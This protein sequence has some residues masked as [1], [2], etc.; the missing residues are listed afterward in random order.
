MKVKI[1]F[2]LGFLV[3]SSCANL[4][5]IEHEKLYIVERESESLAVVSRESTK[6]ISQLG[7]MNHATMKF[8]KGY[9]YILAR[10]GFIS[11]IDVNKDELVKKVKIGKSGIGLTFSED[12][13]VIVNYDPNSVVIL[14]LDL[15]V[16]KTIETPSRNVGVKFWNNLLVFSLMDS[17][18]IWV[19]D[20]NQDYKIVKKFNDVGLLPFDALVKD[21]IYIVGFFN[22]NSIGVLDLS[23]LA[24]QKLAL[25]GKDSSATYKVPHFGYWGI[26][27]DV[28]LVPL[29]S[30]TSL[31]AFDL[32]TLAPIKEIPLIGKPVF[33]S[34]SPDKKKVVVSYSGDKENYISIVDTNSM[35]KIQ[36]VK[37]GERVMHLRYSQD[38]LRLYVTS[39]FD[40]KLKIFN[41]DDW[42]LVKEEKISAPSGIFIKE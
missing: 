29:V 3:L 20:K 12:D 7:N 17:N 13:V 24:Y 4:K 16:K 14:D 9:G 23:K 18:Q 10:D 8:H 15:N 36:D 26:V 6:K 35:Q 40:N 30:G 38:G 5:R 19:L 41:T 21:N 28:A 31:L 37:A 42:K 22:E 2:L 25:A 33:A 27:N 34:V 39:Y 1:F 32:K 11:K